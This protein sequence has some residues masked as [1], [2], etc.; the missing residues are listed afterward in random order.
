MDTNGYWTNTSVCY[1][2]TP[3]PPMMVLVGRLLLERRGPSDQR[4]GRGPPRGLKCHDP[5]NPQGSLKAQIET[6]PARQ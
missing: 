5:V 2:M 4:R 3:P 6:N 1:R